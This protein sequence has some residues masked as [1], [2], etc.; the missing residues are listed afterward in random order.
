MI[1]IQPEDIV[2]LYAILTA[3]K[4]GQTLNDQLIEE[5]LVL[6]QGFTQESIFRLDT[7]RLFNADLGR[8]NRS[9]FL[10]ML[11]Y[12]AKF[13]IMPESFVDETETPFIDTGLATSSF[14][15]PLCDLFIKSKRDVLV[16]ELPD[17]QNVEPEIIRGH[18]GFIMMGQLIEPLYENSVLSCLN[19]PWLYEFLSLFDAV[20]IG[21]ARERALATDLLKKLLT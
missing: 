17:L 14:A 4:S 11:I 8:V 19:N 2:V 21:Q 9:G 12:G 5:V 3:E 15:P 10:E 20:R 16:W 7:V 13:F 1:G 18:Q 6:P